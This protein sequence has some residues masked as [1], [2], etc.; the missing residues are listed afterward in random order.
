MESF[1]G[2]EDRKKMEEKRN[3]CGFEGRAG[4]YYIDSFRAVA[5]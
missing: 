2:I 1:S 4:V 5:V 3:G